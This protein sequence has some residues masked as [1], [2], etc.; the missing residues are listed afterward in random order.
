MAALGQAT[1]Q[2]IEGKNKEIEESHEYLE[3]YRRDI[4]HLEEHIAH[5]F[6][7]KSQNS[8]EQEDKNDQASMLSPLDFSRIGFKASHRLSEK[9]IDFRFSEE[10]NLR[11]SKKSS[12]KTA[13]SESHQMGSVHSIEKQDGIFSDHMRDPQGITP[14]E[15]DSDRVIHSP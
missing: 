14:Q 8:V 9:P 10:E 2:Q 13:F 7:S 12:I 5:Q 4:T 3:S 15:R 11:D 6:Y 1:Q